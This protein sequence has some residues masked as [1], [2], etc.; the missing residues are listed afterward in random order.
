M[1]NHVAKVQQFDH[2]ILQRA[3]SLFSKDKD[4]KSYY[5]AFKEHKE[6]LLSRLETM[7]SGPRI[8]DR[9]SL[10]ACFYKAVFGENNLSIEDGIYMDMLHTFDDPTISAISL[11][12]YGLI[13]LLTK[14]KTD[15]PVV[16]NFIQVQSKL[17]IIQIRRQLR[18]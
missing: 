9:E 13:E 6:R 3:L 16:Q 17:L 7:K 8:D 14:D 10:P 1:Q 12:D 4:R 11:Y 5:I 15:K 2:F 18:L